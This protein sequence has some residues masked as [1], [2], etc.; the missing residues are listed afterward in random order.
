[1]WGLDR[2]WDSTEDSF[3]EWWDPPP[4]NAPN[5]SSFHLFWAPLPTCLFARSKV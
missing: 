1:M 3:L 4:Q 5:S 2:G